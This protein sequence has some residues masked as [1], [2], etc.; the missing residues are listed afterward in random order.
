[1]IYLDTG[2]LVSAITLRDGKQSECQAL[3]SR[4]DAVTSTHA[5]AETFATLTGRYGVRNDI[6][7]EA[8][9]SIV[10]A[11]RVET[12]ALK[13]YRAVLQTSRARGVQGGMV[14]D[15]LHSQVASRLEVEKLYT[16][17][18]SHFEHVAPNLS[19]AT[20]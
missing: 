11:I 1:M 17:N 6:A 12:I 10:D 8:V 9:L 14:Y 20:P 7:A 13:D 16:F 5:L 19:I 4:S 2:I 3:L 18:V 15:A